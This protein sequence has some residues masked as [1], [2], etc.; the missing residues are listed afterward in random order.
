MAIVPY[1]DD[2]FRVVDFD[3]YGSKDELLSELGNN[4]ISCV[5]IT[6]TEN[7]IISNNNIIT[8][9]HGYYLFSFIFIAMSRIR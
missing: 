9:C 4:N 3:S 8:C 7:F 6:H 1:N 2:V 5:S